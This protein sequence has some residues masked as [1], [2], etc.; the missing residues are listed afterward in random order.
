M[1]IVR[2]ENV[3][4]SAVLFLGSTRDQLFERVRQGEFHLIPSP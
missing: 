1:R 4:R 3:I 2:D